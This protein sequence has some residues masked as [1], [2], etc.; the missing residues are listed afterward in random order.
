MYVLYVNACKH[1][2]SVGVLPWIR[3]KPGQVPCCLGWSRPQVSR[4]VQ[5]KVVSCD[6][7]VLA[8]QISTHS[9]NI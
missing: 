5:S 4:S 6:L 1:T 8:K 2:Q 3:A 9:S 7:Q